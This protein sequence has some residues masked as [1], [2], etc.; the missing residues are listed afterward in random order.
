MGPPEPTADTLELTDGDE[1]AGE[2]E[3]DEP[4][5]A[6]DDGAGRHR[7][8]L[9]LLTRR[10]YDATVRDLFA[11]VPDGGCDGADDCPADAACVD[12]ACVREVC[13]PYAF[14]LDAGGAGWTTVHVAG[15][16]NDWAPTIADG[17]FALDYDEGDDAWSGALDLAAGTHEY[18]FVIDETTWIADPDNPDTAPDGLGGANSVATV[19]CSQ[20]EVSASESFSADFPVESRPEDYPFDNSAEAG[21]VTAV[22]VEQ[23]MSAAEAVA[24]K[25]VAERSQWLGCDG[26]GEACARTFAVD[27]G[28]RVFRRPLTGAEVD[29]YAELVLSE[30]DFDAGL[31][32]A[33]QVMLASPYFLYRFEVGDEDGHLDGYE[34]AAALSYGLWGTTPDAALL[35]AA[36]AGELDTADGLRSHARRMLDDERARAVIDVFAAQWLDV[37]RITT[38]DKNPALFPDFDAAVREAMAEETRRFVRH[39]VFEGS[40]RFEELLDARYTFANALLAAHYGLSVEGSGYAK[41][42]VGP[43]RAG[44]LGQGSVLASY[45]HSDQT[46]PVRRG[47]L[48]RERLLCQELGIPPPDAGGVPDVDPDATT[49]ERFEQHMDDPVCRACHEQIDLIGFGF[50]SFDAVGAYREDENG[51]PI[52][53]S[54]RIIGLD[55]ED[56]AFETL[57]ELADLVAGSTAAPRCFARNYS[58][59]IRG[60]VEAEDDC[61]VER[62]QDEFVAGDGEIAELIIATITS[63]EYRQRQ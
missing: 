51:S 12:A 5:E 33:L 6:C 11:I 53:A 29:R 58:R 25:A 31:Q 36:A 45:A 2:T 22:H 32:V 38:T 39:V 7:R 4:G 47:L 56:H 52:D 55:G 1:T 37:E 63:P 3:G 15:S 21:L 42:D 17:G 62:L 44:L 19:T 27:V 48:V 35:D 59:F 20:Q 60:H 49:R 54:G 30:D 14:R 61:A 9:R 41:V 40:G 28:R 50:E 34:L 16:M 57:P 10:E 46:S 43:Q 24:R 23:Y 26:T 13:E 18:K 8:Q